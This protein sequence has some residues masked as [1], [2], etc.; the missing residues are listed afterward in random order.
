MYIRDTIGEGDNAID[1]M[2]NGPDTQVLAVMNF[3]TNLVNMNNGGTY[4]VSKATVNAHKY[5]QE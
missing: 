4:H 5:K 2:L 1:F 3:I